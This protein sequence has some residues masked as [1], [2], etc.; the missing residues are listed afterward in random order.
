MIIYP[1]QKKTIDKNIQLKYQVDFLPGEDYLWYSLEDKY[2]SFVT[3]LL[4]GP[5]VAL[6]I[7]AM[8]LGEDIV[9]RGA[10][11]ERLF[12]NLSGPYQ[13][14]LTHIIPSLNLVKVVPEELVT[15]KARAT[16]VATG[17]SC[18]IDSL[19]VLADH[20]YTACPSG[21]KITHL[22]FNNV[23]SHGSGANRLFESR[24]ENNQVAAERIGLPL[25]KVDS[26]LDDFY[27]GFVFSHTH[28]PRHASIPLLL[29]N[30]IGRYL[31]ASAYSYPDTY[32]KPSTEMSHA[33]PIALPLLTTDSVDLITT[34]SEY[35]RIE[36]TIK[37]ANLPL[38][39]E[40]LD[41][42]VNPNKA[43]NCS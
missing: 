43:G 4:G 41:V 11:S 24:Y 40:V 13:V 37:V 39:Y 17:F 3:N 6:L 42:C 30:G 2:D 21:F 34:G 29:Q 7:P 18:G 12:Y 25:I 26:N 8:A 20:Y 35:S 9:V 15:P 10:I 1:L 31:Y 28:V 38:S 5:L 16:G 36:K 27:H 14:L 23:G 33:D 32:V 19:C 22:I